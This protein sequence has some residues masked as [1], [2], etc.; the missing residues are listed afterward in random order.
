MDLEIK[1]YSDGLMRFQI[2]N[3]ASRHD[4]QPHK[5]RDIDNDPNVPACYCGCL[6]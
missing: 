4:D 6:V 5:Q 2:E 1:V 3:Q